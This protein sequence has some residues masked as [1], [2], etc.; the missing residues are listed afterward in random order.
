MPISVS[1]QLSATT[2]DDPSYEIKPSNWNSAHAITLNI[3]GTD[4][5]NAFSNS[6]NITFGLAPGGQVTASASFSQSTFNQSIQ[7]QNSVQVQGS[8]GAIIFANSNGITFGGVGSV[9][10]ASY[11]TNVGGA[12]ISALGSSQNSGTVVF[13]NSNGVSFGM[14]GSTITATVTAFASVTAGIGAVQVPNATY[15][16]GTVA[17]LNSNGI[18]FGSS[19]ANSITASYTVP[20]TTNFAGTGFSTSTVTGSQLAGTHNTTG[21]TLGVPAWITTYT[22][23]TGFSGTNATGTLNSNGLAISVGVGGGGVSTVGIYGI[24]NTTG[25]SSTS[26]YNLSSLPIGGY[27]I[28]SVGQSLGTIQ[29][30]APQAS[31]LSQMSVGISGG[32]TSGNTG[33]VAQGQVVFAGGANVTLSGS[34]NGSNMTIT[35]SAGTAA[36]APVNFSAG[37]TSGNLGSVV[38]SNSNG[39]SFGLS[40]STITGSANAGGGVFAGVSNLGNF[41]GS[42]GTISTGNLVFAGFGGMTLSQS[43]GGAGSNATISISAPA[44]SSLVAG[45][46]NI[47][48]S[49]G[50]STISI[51]GATVAAAPVN[52]SAG[53]TSG[54]LSSVVF[55]NSNN[56][57]FG[58]SGSTITGSYTVPNTAVLVGTGATTTTQ[59]GTALGVTQNTAGLSLA[60]PQWITTYAPGAGVAISAAGNSISNSTVVFSNA[61]NVTFGMAGSTITASVTGGGGGVGISAAGQSA[62]AGVITFSNSNRVSFGMAGS[63]LT[64]S[65][66]TTY[67]GTGF[68]SASTAGSVIVG[69]LNTSG[70]SLGIP[71]WLTTSNSVANFSAGVSFLG[72]NA[73]ATGMTG[74]QIVL[75]GSGPISLSQATGAAG[76]TISILAPATSS[77]VGTGL[78][79]ISTNGS[80]ISI[81]A[82]GQST[83]PVAISGSNGSYTFSTVSFGNSNNISFYSSN[84]SIVASANLAGTGF[85]S[86]S[87]SGLLFGTLNSIGLSVANPYLTRYALNGGYIKTIYAGTQ[88][89]GPMASMG[90]ASYNYM[91]INVPITG[92]RVDGLGMLIG[93]TV[94]STRGIQ[95]GYSVWGA[96]YTRNASTLSQLSSG[97]AT[98]TFGWTSNTTGATWIS[99]VAIRPLSAPMNVN[100]PP[101]EYFVA[102]NVSSSV[103]PAAGVTITTDV[104]MSIFD[105]GGPIGSIAATIGANSYTSTLGY[106]EMGNVTSSSSNW[107]YG[108]G[109]ATATSA[110]LPSSVAISNL[111]ESY[112]PANII[113]LRNA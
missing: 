93:D 25:Q 110:G 4:I 2:P 3:S 83:Q 38:F 82:P 64:G 52:F 98:T 101:G 111:N 81:G 39:V 68:T 65:I 94:N 45:N 67:A 9:I 58:L 17:F 104:N 106:A 86:G 61:N 28:I 24:S 11:N 85:S 72:N 22:Q 97:S 41:A 48:I 60:V 99:Q 90:F 96:I 36:A 21:L 43:T 87:T 70:L 46:T 29:I 33:T 32:N 42:T 51:Y 53:T 59:G 107:Y 74:S 66:A 6:N 13:A 95:L 92:S 31:V 20:A 30:S 76:A 34:T 14:T 47:T 78:V 88:I 62:T 44:T 37:T 5:I 103:A 57:S 35:V 27:G 113:I 16:S 18:S 12:A 23:A 50:G 89:S 26:S 69:T 49:T 73:G 40:G 80:T 91:S 71:N 8:S 7:T 75:V 10:T 77:I 55:S 102:F 108:A 56:F 109:I 15:T 84:G 79:S 19:G 63:V 1:H 105:F 100:M 54:N 112:I